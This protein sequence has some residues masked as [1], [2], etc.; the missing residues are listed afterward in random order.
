MESDLCANRAVDDR[1]GIRHRI[2]QI[3]RRLG[4]D[5]PQS[6]TR[7]RS[8]SY[9]VWTESFKTVKVQL[10]ARGLIVPSD[11]KKAASDRNTYWKLTPYGLTVMTQ[12]RAVPKAAPTSVKG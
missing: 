5:V 2:P 6:S 1:R 8:S 9:R 3:A 4:R 10:M 11:R 7:L 12:L